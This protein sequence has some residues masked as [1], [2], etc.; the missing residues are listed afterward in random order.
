MFLLFCLSFPDA[1]DCRPFGLVFTICAM[2]SF[3]P[4]KSHILKAGGSPDSVR[5][6]V[7]RGDEKRKKQNGIE[8]SVATQ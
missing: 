1:R 2:V 5:G 8:E 6:E 4:I 3:I 7:R